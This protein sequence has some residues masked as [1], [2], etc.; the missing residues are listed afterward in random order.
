MNHRKILADWPAERVNMGHLALLQ[1]LPSRHAERIGAFL[2]LHHWGPYDVEPGRDPVDLGPHPHRGFEP[3]SFVFSGELE[4][5][6]SRG[7]HGIVGPGGVQWMTAG[8][9]IVHSEHASRRFKERGGTMEGIQLWINLP[10]DKKMVQPAYLNLPA[11]KQALIEGDGWNGRVVAGE[12]AGAKGPAPTHVDLVVAVLHLEAGA[13]F[14]AALPSG[15]EAFLYLLDGKVEGIAG[16][17]LIRFSPDGDGVSAR[18]EEPTRALLLASEPLDEPVATYGPFVMNDQT[19]IMQAI[20]D[21][22]M[23]KMGVLVDEPAETSKE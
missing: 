11:G 6:D 21:Y 14:E 4:H 9:G 2:L 5:R 22:Q 1:P 8:M 7:H 3:V 17:G 13:V 19:Q 18:A 15:H 16:P 10:A 23:G 20:R 12:L